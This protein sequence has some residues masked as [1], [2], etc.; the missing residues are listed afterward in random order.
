MAKSPNKKG[1]ENSSASHSTSQDQTESS[2]TPLDEFMKL[3]SDDP[4]F[5]EAKPSGKGFVIGGVKS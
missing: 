3:I 4:Q 1:A 5:E 2:E